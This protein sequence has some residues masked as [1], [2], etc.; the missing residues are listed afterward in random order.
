MSH[1]SVH[2]PLDNFGPGARLG[3]LVA[4]HDEEL[5][6][7]RQFV[8]DRDAH[9]WREGSFDGGEAVPPILEHVWPAALQ[10]G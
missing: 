9:Y 5:P 4:A 10:R 8:R 2:P 7:L 3:V 6:G 1:R